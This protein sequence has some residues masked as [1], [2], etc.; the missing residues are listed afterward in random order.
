M[1]HV[2]HFNCRTI[3]SILKGC[4][5][6]PTTR[7][8]LALCNVCANS[9]NCWCCCCCCCPI[10]TY[11]RQLL[12]RVKRQRQQFLRFKSYDDQQALAQLTLW[13]A[14]GG[15]QGA[16]RVL[17]IAR[18]L[19]QWICVQM[20]ITKT[21]SF[22]SDALSAKMLSCLGLIA[23]CNC[24]SSE[25][26]RER[27]GEGEVGTEAESKCCGGLVVSQPPT[28]SFVQL[29]HSAKRRWL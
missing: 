15:R 7:C 10:A 23:S 9:S 18:Y 3:G 14:G 2:P 22:G 1:L 20:R 11:E 19:L 26:R 24:V 28:H 4:A 21:S 12:Q 27:E 13:A 25:S 6:S 8:R 16:W 5:L 17:W 29:I